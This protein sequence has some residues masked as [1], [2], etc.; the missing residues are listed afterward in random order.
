[1]F[2]KITYPYA[3][4]VNFKICFDVNQERIPKFEWLT[5]SLT[6]MVDFERLG[7]LLGPRAPDAD[8]APF[9]KR[10]FELD[11]NTNSQKPDF[12]NADRTF[13]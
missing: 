3:G 5:N 8:L 9:R 2:D 6:E 10:L 7:A 4:T 12:C 1:M 11:R 13:G